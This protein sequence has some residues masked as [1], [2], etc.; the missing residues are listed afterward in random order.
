MLIAFLFLLFISLGEIKIVRE[1]GQKLI[2]SK[3]VDYT[4]AW[5]FSA[6]A[7]FS[8]IS[9]SR[10]AEFIA[11]GTFYGSNNDGGAIYFLDKT[12]KLLWKRKMPKG[13][14]CLSLSPEGN[15]LAVGGGQWYYEA[16][17][18][19]E[20]LQGADNTVYL[21]SKKGS[22]LWK[23][24]IKGDKRWGSITDISVS[25][26][27]DYIAVAT[28]EGYVYLFNREGKIL[29]KKKVGKNLEKIAIS[30]NGE[31]IVA[32][33]KYTIYLLNSN[34]NVL[35][36]RSISSI[37]SA[38]AISDDGKQIAIAAFPKIYVLDDKENVVIEREIENISPQPVII[39]FS[40]VVFNTTSHTIAT[41]LYGDIYVFDKNGKALWGAYLGY[42]TEDAKISSHGKY[43]VAAIWNE[44]YFLSKLTNISSSDKIAKQNMLEKNEAES[45]KFDYTLMQN[46]ESL[47]Y[48]AFGIL[49]VFIFFIFLSYYFYRKT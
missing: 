29:W 26:G 36:N 31:H 23:R 28:K 7:R 21:F 45:K 17:Q 30:A 33:I 9:M 15:Y 44:I 46:G 40:P 19:Y 48:L 41:N 32:G 13:V 1:P 22:L 37:V 11:A 39:D 20:V 43:I 35:W 4:I 8:S 24:G 5:N 10:N 16:P 2:E 49:I 34:S 38:V 14:C 25:R 47:N 6:K 42:R 3:K 27:A 18:G 12:G